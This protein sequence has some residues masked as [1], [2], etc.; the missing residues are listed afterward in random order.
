MNLA[1]N[2]GALS[3]PIKEQLR[4]QELK[5]KTRDIWHWQCDADAITR[6]VIRGLISDSTAHAARKRILKKI[7]A[8]VSHAQD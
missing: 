2:F 4:Q 1:I 5:A 7:L 3:P 6:C 8:G